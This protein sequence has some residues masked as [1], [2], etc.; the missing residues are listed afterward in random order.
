MAVCEAG[1][2]IMAYFYFDFRDLKKQSCRDL[3]LSLVS[4]LSSRSRPCCDILHHVYETHE[5]GDRQP[6]DDILKECLKE[7]LRL[8]AQGWIYIVL[9]A[10]DECPDS[11]GLPSPRNEVLQLV[12]KLV[13]LRLYGLHIY[14]QCA[15]G[16]TPLHEAVSDTSIDSVGVHTVQLL[17]EHGADPNIPDH[18]QSTPLHQVSSIGWIEA[19][20]LLLSY[21]ARVDEKD[22]KGR[23]PF[24]LASAEGHDEI[25][26]LLLGHGTYCT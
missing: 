17:L 4:Q 5:S 10:L 22:E 8:L 25:T 24:Q 15:E 12:K 23:T 19:A 16:R 3:L 26:K 9:D 18:E 14:L 21:G 20:Q 7:M 13:D 11:S 1:S 6:S 2:G